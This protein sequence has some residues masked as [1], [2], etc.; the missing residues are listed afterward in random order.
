MPNA[1]ERVIGDALAYDG[2]FVQ[3]RLLTKMGDIETGTAGGMSD[4]KASK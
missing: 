1:A 2:D 4:P 3:A